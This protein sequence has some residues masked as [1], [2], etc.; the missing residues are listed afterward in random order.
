MLKTM[1]SAAKLNC[2]SI[3]LTAKWGHQLPQLCLGFSQ[4]QHRKFIPETPSSPR[5][6]WITGHSIEKGSFY[7]KDVYN[8]W[9]VLRS[10]YEISLVCWPILLFFPFRNSPLW[11]PAH[12]YKG[13][14]RKGY[15]LY[16]RNRESEVTRPHG[17]QNIAVSITNTCFKLI[18][19]RG[20]GIKIS[21]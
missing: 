7:W 19:K 4:F 18:W 8:L 9:P 3:Y 1:N 2:K 13:L 6:T 11:P 15:V 17:D 12:V 10:M 21:A 16:S 20:L 14:R 5:Q